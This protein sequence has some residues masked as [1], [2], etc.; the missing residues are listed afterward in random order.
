MKLLKELEKVCDGYELKAQKIYRVK[1]GEV[2]PDMVYDLRT[3][4]L[5]HP[6][7]YEIRG[8]DLERIVKRLVKD[9]R[10]LL[11]KWHKKNKDL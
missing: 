6:K 3:F 8:Y 11:K 5:M 1:K 10:I 9:Y 4:S 2:A 7:S